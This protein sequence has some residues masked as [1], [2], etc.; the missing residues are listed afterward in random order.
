MQILYT[1][2]DPEF[3]PSKEDLVSLNDD[4]KL[5]DEF[6]EADISVIG[7]VE[8]PYFDGKLIYFLAKEVA[9]L[10][11]RDERVLNNATFLETLR[12]VRR[13]KNPEGLLCEPLE[14]NGSE[15]GIAP[16]NDPIHWGGY[17]YLWTCGKISHGKS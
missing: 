4:F 9:Y 7:R 15:Y 2:H 3:L 17:T 10:T 6:K 5:G 12:S 16:D 8:T 11:V 13:I 1:D 14:F